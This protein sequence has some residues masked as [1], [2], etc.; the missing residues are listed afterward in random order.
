MS[1]LR[2]VTIA[3]FALM[4]ALSLSITI[5]FA[6]K[7]Q[8]DVVDETVG[9]FDFYVDAAMLDS[10]I[11]EA[12]EIQLEKGMFILQ[13][14]KTEAISVDGN[15]KFAKDIKAPTGDSYSFVKRMKTNGKTN[16]QTLDRSISMFLDKKAQ[17]KVYALS[18]SSGDSTRTLSLYK[19][20]NPT[21]LQSLKVAA[22]AG[23]IEPIIFTTEEAGSYY[24][25]ADVNGVNIY[26]VG[27]TY[28]G[29]AAPVT[30]GPWADVTAPTLTNPELSFD[31]NSLIVN[32]TGNI[33]L[34]GADKI[35]VSMKKGE[36]VVQKKTAIRYGASGSL[37]FTPTETGTYTFEAEAVRNGEA[38]TKKTTASVSADFSLVFNAPAV[39]GRTAKNASDALVM[40]A[41]I[42]ESKEATSYTLYYK[43]EA[44]TE[45]KTKT[46]E[47]SNTGEI[48]V[49]LDGEGYVVGDTLIIKVSATRAASAYN[50]EE[51]KESAEIK[52]VIRPQ[53]E[54]DWVF[55]YFGQSTKESLNMLNPERDNNIFDGLSLQAATFDN[56]GRCTGKGGK[57]TYGG[58][59]GISF[60]YTKIKAAE[61]DFRIRANVHVDYLN[62]T[63]DGQEGFALLVRDT[64]GQIGDTAYNYSNS[65]AAIAT[66]I[67]YKQGAA[68]QTYRNGVGSRFVTG[69]ES[70]VDTPDPTKLKHVMYP[71]LHDTIIQG[72]DYIIELQKINNCYYTRYYEKDFSTGEETL[73]MVNENVLYHDADDKDQLLVVD[74]EYVYAGFSVAR[75]CNATFNDIEVEVTPRSTEYIEIKKTPVACDYVIN[76]PTTSSLEDYEFSFFANADGVLDVTLNGAPVITAQAVTNYIDFKQMVKLVPGDNDFV[77]TFTPNASFQPSEYEVMASY[78]TQVIDKKVTFS[79]YMDATKPIYVAPETATNGN[80]GNPGNQGTKESPLNLQTAINYCLPGQTIYLTEGIYEISTGNI[81]VER[82]NDGKVLEDGTILWKTLR[83]DPEAKT[84]PVLDNLNKGGGF[85]IWGNYWHLAGFD[86]TKTAYG[87]KAIQLGGWNNILENVNTYYNGDSGISVS[88]KS[89][90]AKNKW[91]KDN[92]VLNCTSYMNKDQAQ[93]DADGFAAKLYCGEGNKFV[94]CIGYCNADDG[95][96]LYAKTETG[97]IGKVTIENCIAFGNGFN[98]DGT[99]TY[100]NGNGFKMGGESLS[101][102]H[103]ISNCVSFGNK[104]K[105]IDSNSCP[106]II[107][108]NCTSIYNGKYNYAFYSN[109]AVNFSIEKVI[110]LIGG[111]TDD[112]PSQSTPPILTENNYFFYG[113][114]GYGNSIN[115]LEQK[116]TPAQV[117]N[118]WNEDFMKQFGFELDM[119]TRTLLTGSFTWIADKLCA[120]NA[121]QS[122]NIGDFLTVKDTITSG[123]RLQGVPGNFVESGNGGTTEQPQ[124][125][126]KKGCKS[127][128]TGATSVVLFAL[129]AVGVCLLVRKQKSN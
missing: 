103:E 107:V 114:E 129:L 64:V 108:K 20:G 3:I 8:A 76:S 97:K 21:A 115:S 109:K 119:S 40:E 127:S 118:S 61:E 59:D 13:G 60:Y 2:K 22:T 84:R 14:S 55:T 111:S 70:S 72:G 102:L 63:V 4:F 121:D 57:Y 56:D 41:T 106:D 104:L 99:T 78:D 26:F 65:A 10:D 16:H 124:G 18:S 28:T 85:T 89:T 94:G 54:R 45:F 58:H 38:E 128:V 82:G 51:T 31:K 71:L 42:T 100:G 62:P 30:R 66:K 6:P 50:E 73:K 98:I 123:A 74:K 46:I 9:Q 91:P 53:V 27:V 15:P 7:A 113:S 1:N 25:A 5:G 92:L 33:G 125:G 126:C 116:I 96:D 36:E 87:K 105:G 110:S 44:E 37:T 23:T 35:I 11:T 112:I 83:A 43:K 122:I 75:G 101:G 67:Q 77:A 49:L 52:V 17:I 80:P 69:I 24:I 12:K 32:Y 86:V 120:R 117:F 88:G 95:W 34:D 81:T 68:N 90:D 39:R 48:A 79:S 29:E 19:N 47:P 93:E